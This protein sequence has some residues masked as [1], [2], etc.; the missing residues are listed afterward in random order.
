MAIDTY[1]KIEDNVFA[2]FT[3]NRTTEINEILIFLFLC[4]VKPIWA[5]VI[6]TE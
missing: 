4:S 5:Q 1:F 6:Y 2:Y 3:N